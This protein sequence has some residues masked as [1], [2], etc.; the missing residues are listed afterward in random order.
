MFIP[1][2]FAVGGVSGSGFRLPILRSSISFCRHR[3]DGHPF[4]FCEREARKGVKYRASMNIVTESVDTYY[5]DCELAFRYRR[6][7]VLFNE[8][9]NAPHVFKEPSDAGQKFKEAAERSK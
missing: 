1:H 7:E 9:L 6:F 2:P 5:L 3:T 4:T 8:V